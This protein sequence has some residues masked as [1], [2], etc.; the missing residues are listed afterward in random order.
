MGYRLFVD[1]LVK[2]SPVDD[3]SV[4]QLRSQ[5]SDRVQ[6]DSRAVAE[7]ASIALSTV[8]S[9]AGL[10]T[11]PKQA[12]VTLRQIEFLPIYDRRVLTILVTSES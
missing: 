8:T 2:F 1:T 12:H 9:L 3:Q 7:T 11:L 4:Q 10:V 6:L 5:L